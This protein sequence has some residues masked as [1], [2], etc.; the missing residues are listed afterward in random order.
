MA[1]NKIVAKCESDPVLMAW[2][3]RGTCQYFKTFGL[4]KPSVGYD[5]RELLQGS[6]L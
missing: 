2:E 3:Y 1:L 6:A 4:L 5:R